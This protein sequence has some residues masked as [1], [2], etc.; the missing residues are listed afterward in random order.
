MK[1]PM[2]FERIQWPVGHGGFHTGKLKGGSADFRYF[3]DCGALS[4]E[5]KSLI[6]EK[7]K[8]IEFDF[9][10]ISHFDHDHYSELA[11]A[12]QLSVLFIPYMTPTDMVLH[13]LAD[14][15]TNA[16]PLNKA[17]EGFQLLKQLEAKG[18]RI[19]M[20]DGRS[21]VGVQDGTPQGEP[22]Q[23][24]GGL[25]MRIPIVRGAVKGTQVMRHDVAVKVEL[26]A[27]ALIQF[28]FFNHRVE[29]ASRAFS[30]QLEEAVNA[31]LL[32]KSD[33]TPY[34]R[35]DDFLTDV[36][37]GEAHVVRI[38]GKAMQKVYEKTLKD[39]ILK[40]S[41][42]TSSNLSSLTMFSCL[43]NYRRLRD[44]HIRSKSMRAFNLDRMHSDND[45][46]W[47]LT[48]DLELTPQTWPAFNDHY[49]CELPECGI[50]NVPHHGSGISLCEEA[51]ILLG[52]QYFVMP[53][54]TEDDKHPAEALIERLNRHGMHHRQNVTTAWESTVVLE[55]LLDTWR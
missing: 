24:R 48:G 25:S 36:A 11:S 44:I 40:A 38:N 39:P 31:G 30:L 37:A 54:N 2:K 27:E 23:L 50:F 53:V 9:G 6:C 10:V 13:A 33:K 21:G 51:V 45:F 34:S 41:G 16:L 43:A 8:S 35:V 15:A 29:E 14:H 20:V 26:D 46:G 4:K 32:K 3:F 12:E 17:F 47:M 19:V 1:M 42:I 55:V 28:K 18:T 52:D 49:F 7:L 5:G 22:E